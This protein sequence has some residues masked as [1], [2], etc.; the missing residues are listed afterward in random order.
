MNNKQPITEFQGYYRFLSNFW[1]CDIDYDGIVYPS[2][3]HAYQAAKTNDIETKKLI[4][5]LKTPGEAKRCGRKIKIREDWDNIKLKV[6]YDINKLKY[7]CPDLA[8]K[9]MLTEGKEIIEGNKW[10][11]TF[12]GVCNGVG[13]NHLGNILM[14]IREE[15]ITDVIVDNIVGKTI[16]WKSLED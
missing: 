4:V 12:W 6:M 5:N 2:T 11:D 15:L 16:F 7:E 14:K 10:N 8:A 13:D 9:L 1:P 3:E